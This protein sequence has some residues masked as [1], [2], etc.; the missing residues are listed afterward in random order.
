MSS[1]CATRGI[2]GR[3]LLTALLCIVGVASVATPTTATATITVDSVLDIVAADGVCSLREAVLAA[4]TDQAVGGCVAGSGADII[5]FSPILALPATFTLTIAGAAEDGNLTGDLDLMGNLTINSPGADR[6][7]LDG[8]DT[9]RVLDIRPGAHVTLTGLTVRNGNSG[10]AT[11]GGIK[12]A[13]SLTLNNST[14]TGNRNGGITNDG[15]GLV[16]NNV[17]VTDNTGGYGIVNQNRATLGFASGLV[18]GNQGGGI[19]NTASSATLNNLMIASNAGGGVYNRG[20]SPTSLTISSS[21]VMSNTATSGGG[22]FNEG[23]GAQAEIHNTT[24]AA[25]TAAM[26]GGGVFNNGILILNSSTLDHNHARSGGGIDHFGGHL[27]LTNGTFSANTASDNGGGLY[28]RGSAVLTHVTF[29]WNTANGP[30]T[31]GALFNDSTSITLHGVIVAGSE[32]DANCY[33]SEGF[34]T[35]S[36]HNLDSGN[37]CQFSIAGDLINTDPQL[38][39]LQANGGATRTHA[40]LA[41]SPAIDAGG[42]AACPTADQRGAPRPVDG[43]DDGVA[44][45]DIGSVESQSAAT[46][47]ASGTVCIGDGDGRCGPSEIPLAGVLVTSHY[48]GPDGNLD[49]M[50][51]VVQSVRTDDAGNYSLTGLKPGLYRVTEADPVGYASIADADGGSPNDITINLKPD[52]SLLGQDFEDVVPQ[53]SNSE[54]LPMIYLQSV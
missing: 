51:D 10:A 48:A 34:I 49:T 22:I 43:N 39:P 52:Q 26:S 15:G 17:N 33:N 19:A 50:D 25:N 28:N 27:T 12:V 14:L 21:S 6:I 31:G 18:S 54:Y 7:I 36:G 4:N 20:V 1:V 37:T 16:L 41:G 3:L 35:S 38:G 45:C 9:D 23:I 29:A 47:T 46:A 53:K 40:P 32:A 11:G 2:R 5:E 44:T 8:N 42:N 13:G 30:D 24:I